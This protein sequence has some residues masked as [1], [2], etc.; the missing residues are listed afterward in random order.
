MIRCPSP[1]CNN[2]WQTGE[3]VKEERDGV[4]EQKV[5]GERGGVGNE[6][7]RRGEELLCLLSWSDNGTHEMFPL[8]A[9]NQAAFSL[10]V[11]HSV[12]PPSFF[13]SAPLF[14]SFLLLSSLKQSPPLFRPRPALCRREARPL[15]CGQSRPSDHC[16]VIVSKWTL[17][18][19]N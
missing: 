3:E 15:L 8:R 10:S 7:G 5:K 17:D 18:R 13:L 12:C 14:V 4:G 2:E 11:Y 9:V 19:G 6:I 1:E 16:S